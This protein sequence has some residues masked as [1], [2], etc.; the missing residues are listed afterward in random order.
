MA[1]PQAANDPFD[2]GAAPSVDSQTSLQPVATPGSLRSARV[3][4]WSWPSAHTAPPAPHAATSRLVELLQAWKQRSP[5]LRLSGVLQFHAASLRTAAG[6]RIRA[7]RSG[8]QLPAWP[9]PAWPVR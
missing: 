3:R 6:P 7:G 4:A 1:Q 8:P 2:A 5:V 9:A